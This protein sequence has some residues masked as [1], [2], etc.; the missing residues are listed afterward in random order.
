[1]AARNESG[2][3]PFE[4]IKTY[5]GFWSFT[6]PLTSIF[7]DIPTCW[8]K[9][10]SELQLSKVSFMES[11][12]FDRVPTTPIDEDCVLMPAIVANSLTV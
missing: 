12:S 11:G 2:F 7:P 5:C 6:L 1:M 9:L 8:A 4:V 3:F 10:L